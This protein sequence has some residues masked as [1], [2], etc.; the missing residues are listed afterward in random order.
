MSIS[1]QEALDSIR[2]MLKNTKV[3]TS[4][5]D[6]RDGN[7]LYILKTNKGKDLDRKI[8]VIV[9]E[10]DKESIS[11][12]YLE[13]VTD[14]AR[15]LYLSYFSTV[16]EFLEECRN[17]I[18]GVV[19]KALLMSYVNQGGVRISSISSINSTDGN[20]NRGKDSYEHIKD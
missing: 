3:V 20:A 9:S 12:I 2:E 18:S 10:T 14:N 16:E 11:D 13:V 15:N 19:R 17:N 4:K 1:K 8:H 6:I 7:Y 5:V